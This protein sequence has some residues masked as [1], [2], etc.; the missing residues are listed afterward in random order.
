MAA[1][2]QQQ[3]QSSPV[4]VAGVVSFYM[5]AALVMVF[6]NKAV[7]NSS[8]ELP[9]LFLFIQLLIAVVL[10]HVSATLSHKVEIPR[11]E[12]ETAK[13]LTPVVLVNIIGLIFNTLCLRDVEA[14]FFQIARGMQLPLTILVSSISTR[15]QPTTRVLGAAGIVTIGFLLGVSPA[16]L[17]SLSFSLTPAVPTVAN[18]ALRGNPHAAPGIVSLIYGVLS[19]LFIAFHSVLIKSSL[20][21][22]GGSTIQLAYWTNLGSA[23]F[24]VPFVLLKGEI[25]K[26]IDL[27]MGGASSTGGEWNMS[28]FVWGTLVTGIFGFLLCV[29]GLLSI[30]VTSPITHMFSSAARS[31]LQ[32]LLGVWLFGDLLNVNRALSIIVILLGTMFYTWAKHFEGLQRSPS[33]G[34]SGNEAI[35]MKARDLENQKWNRAGGRLETV[36]EDESESDE[37]VLFD[38]EKHGSRRD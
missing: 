4:Q 16:S 9:L 28:V 8:P 34:P 38:V 14:S 19:A 35:G 33:S 1:P 3:Q 37:D 21:H 24:L 27:A 18:P 23:L 29:A 17:S 10:L 20:P 5:G 30:K 15:S 12:L 2:N 7:L 22:C 11:L 6:V 31:V 25:F 13:K 32:T 36:A 26:V